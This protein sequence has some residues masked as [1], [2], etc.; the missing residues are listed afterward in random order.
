[1]LNEFEC[2]QHSIGRPLLVGGCVATNNEC[3]AKIAP[4]TADAHGHVERHQ[5]ACFGAAPPRRSAGRTRLKVVPHFSNRLTDLFHRSGLHLGK[6][7]DLAY[8]RR[9]DLGRSRIGGLAPAH[10]VPDQS[11]FIRILRASQSSYLG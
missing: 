2:R 4:V 11:H 8:A 1:L 10:R 5:F 3:A 9:Q 7:V 6:H